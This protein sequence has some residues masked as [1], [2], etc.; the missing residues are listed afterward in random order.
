MTTKLQE[1]DLQASEVRAT[2]ADLAAAETP[3]EAKTE[4][5][6]RSVERA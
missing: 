3:D 6:A 1:I 2:L 4:S 5:G